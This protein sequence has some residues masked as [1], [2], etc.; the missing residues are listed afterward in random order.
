MMDSLN[1]FSKDLPT[2]F[3]ENKMKWCTLML[4]TPKIQ[5]FYTAFTEKLAVI[6]KE[7]IEKNG[8]ILSHYLKQPRKMMSLDDRMTVKNG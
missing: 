6:M 5:H 4:K 2:L 7:E 3:R 8:D 1:S